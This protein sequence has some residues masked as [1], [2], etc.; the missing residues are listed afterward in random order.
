MR[1]LDS[2]LRDNDG[3][4]R[5]LKIDTE[6]AEPLVLAGA[7]TTLQQWRPALVILEINQFGLQQLGFSQMDA[8]RPLQELGY[9]GYVIGQPLQRLAP[10]EVYPAQ[11]FDMVFVTPD[12]S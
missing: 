9:N 8:R 2:L 4:L 11:L 6:G 1:T 12:F 10:D 3:P 7:K 5:L